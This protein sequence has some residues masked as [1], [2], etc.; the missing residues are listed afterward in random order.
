[1]ASIPT[2]HQYWL[3]DAELHPGDRYAEGLFSSCGLMAPACPP[4]H[5]RLMLRIPV[6]VPAGQLDSSTARQLRAAR[7]SDLMAQNHS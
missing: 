6:S 3:Q 4:S 7:G 5:L 2:Y 1:M